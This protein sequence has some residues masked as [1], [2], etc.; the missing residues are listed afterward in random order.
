M[1]RRV[2]VASVLVPIPT[3][4]ANVEVPVK[5]EVPVTP[6]FKTDSREPSNVRFEDDASVL[7]LLVYRSVPA[8][9]NEV[10]PVPPRLTASVP[11]VSLSAMPNVEVATAETVLSAL[12]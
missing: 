9:P 11:V 5:V 1:V 8:L 12:I 7:A 3:L 10:T 6:K 4:P 2:P